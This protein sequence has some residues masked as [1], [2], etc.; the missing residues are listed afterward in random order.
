[1]YMMASIVYLVFGLALTS[2]C[3]NVVQEKLSDS[4]RQASAKIGA[5]IGLRVSDEDGTITPVIQGE[6]PEVHGLAVNR[7]D[8]FNLQVNNLNNLSVAGPPKSQ[9][10]DISET[11]R[12]LK[13][14][15]CL[16]HSYQKIKLP[17]PREM[18]DVSNA[19]IPTSRAVKRPKSVPGIKVQVIAHVKI[20]GL[21]YASRRGALYSSRRREVAAGSSRELHKPAKRLQCRRLK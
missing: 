18:G 6:L 5:T 2:M 14:T 8:S 11:D 10:T 15:V 4:F 1:M 16:A 13:V 17:S 19:P 21:Q 7:S 9:S 3:I 20:P 12:S